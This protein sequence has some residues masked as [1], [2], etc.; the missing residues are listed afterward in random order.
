MNHVAWSG[1]WSWREICNNLTVNTWRVVD[2]S[3]LLSPASLRPFCLTLIQEARPSIAHLFNDFGE[4]SYMEQQNSSEMF[5]T[6]YF[7]SF[8]IWYIVTLVL[9]CAHLV[10]CDIRLGEF[11]FSSGTVL[12][13]IFMCLYLTPNWFCLLPM[14]K[15]V[16]DPVGI[17]LSWQKCRPNSTAPR[18][19]TRDLARPNRTIWNVKPFMMLFQFTPHKFWYVFIFFL[20]KLA[21]ERCLGKVGKGRLGVINF[22]I[23]SL[24]YSQINKSS[25]KQSRSTLY[26]KYRLCMSLSASS[27]TASSLPSN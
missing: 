18:G 20:K 25:S 12:V 16:P 23:S 2:L 8:Y 14:F 26:E 15:S 9:Y 1:F 10:A 11:N 7:C 22:R 5:L 27:S 21:F 19:W 3:V 13:S 17:C 24:T 6:D 4:L